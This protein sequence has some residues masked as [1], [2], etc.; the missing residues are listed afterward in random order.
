MENFQVIRQAVQHTHQC[1]GSPQSSDAAYFLHILT[2]VH[3]QRVKG[4]GAVP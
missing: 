3:A 4:I 2:H 1:P